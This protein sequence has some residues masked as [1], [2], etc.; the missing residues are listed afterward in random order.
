MV[1]LRIALVR[2]YVLHKMRRREIAGGAR[3]G[4]GVDGNREPWREHI[5]FL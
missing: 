2:H 5:T 3:G 4:A 1:G